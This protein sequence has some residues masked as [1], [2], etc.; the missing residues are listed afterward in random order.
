M[1]VT[2][3]FG[4]WVNHGDRC[5][6]SVESTFAGYIGGADPE[7][8]ER[9]ENDG[10]FDSMVAAFRSEINAALP[11]NVALCGNDFY[12]PYYTADCD[13]D[14]YPTDEH[15]ALDITEIIAGID[16]EPILERYDPD[17]VKQDAT[18]SVGPN[19]WHTLTIGDTAVD[20]PVRSNEV[21]PVPLLHELAVQALTEHEWELTGVW[22]RTPA[23]FTATATLSA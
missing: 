16:L 20:L 10:Y 8:R 21:I 2:T 23:G 17:L 14:G 15:G 6:V 18:L 1:T 5:N 22:E 13:F 4:T 3:E 7:W 12:G 11:T 9:V 19:G